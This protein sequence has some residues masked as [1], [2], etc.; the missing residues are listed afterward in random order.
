VEPG[1]TVSAFGQALE[2][3]CY[4]ALNENGIQWLSELTPK[5]TLLTA[6]QR[7]AR[8]C[9]LAVD[10]SYTQSTVW[11]ARRLSRRVRGAQ[12]PH[13]K[14]VAAGHGPSCQSLHINSKK[15]AVKAVLEFCPEIPVSLDKGMENPVLGSHREV[16]LEARF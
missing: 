5:D 4:S 1:W 14:W 8:G 15:G 7:V 9:E 13:P 3:N 16:F 6:R 11:T 12:P 2:C 10:Q